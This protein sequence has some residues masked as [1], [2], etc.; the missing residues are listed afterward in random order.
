[1]AGFNIIAFR[2]SWIKASKS[3][4]KT[5]LKVFQAASKELF[6]NIVDSTPVL[7]GY[8]K[9]N[10]QVTFDNPADSER[11]VK[12]KSGNQVKREINYKTSKLTEKNE[13]F[14]TNL[15]PYAERIEY[16]GY[17]RIKAPA[18]MVR[19][20]VANWSY[21]VSKWARKLGKK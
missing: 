1:M 4:T 15:A 21:I 19:V 18:G 10:W 3:A 5:T 2:N 17:S 6:T 8:L 7:T 11:N 16:E 9:G 13:L 20:N 12:D 14:F